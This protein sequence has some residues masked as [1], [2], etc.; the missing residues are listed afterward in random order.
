MTEAYFAYFKTTTLVD[1]LFQSSFQVPVMPLKAPYRPETY[2][3]EGSS[4]PICSMRQPQ[5]S[6][7]NL[8]DVSP[9]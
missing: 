1:N 4:L 6:C 9:I 5:P 8:L 3:A 2:I 7:C